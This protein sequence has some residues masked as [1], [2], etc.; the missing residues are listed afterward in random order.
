MPKHLRKLLSLCF[1]TMIG[2]FTSLT[3]IGQPVN[4]NCTEAILLTP[5]TSCVFTQYTNAGATA[6]T[7]VDNPIC[8]NY[9]GMDVWFKFVVPSTGS[10]EIDAQTGTM[11]DG[12][13][14]LYSGVCGALNQLT[15]DDDNSANGLMP[16]I[17][18]SGLV[19]GSTAYI[20]FWNYGT[21]MPGTFS[22]CVK[23]STSSGACSNNNPGGCAC[24]TPGATDC[25]L[26][27][28]IIAGK[29]SLNDNT[30][31]SEYSQLINGVNKGLLR[32]DVSTPNVG[33]GPMEVTPTN[34]Y[35]CGGDTMRNFFPATNFLCP[36]GSYPKRLINQRIYHKIGNT[37]EYLLRPAGYMQYHPA[38]GHIH[39]DGWGLYTLRLKDASIADTIKWPIVN[40]G[41]KVSFCLIDLTTCSGS[42]GDCRDANGTILNNGSFPNYGLGGGY[43]CGNQL[44]GISV[45]KVDI[46]HRNLDESFVK[47]PYEACNGEYYAMIE[48]DPDNHFLEM[49]ENNN[50]LAAKVPL[51]QQRTTNTGP[52]AYIFSKKGNVMCQGDVMELV[53]SGASNYV[54]STGETTQK[55]NVS[56]PGRYWV[57]AT[58][59]CGVATSDTLDLF[60]SGASSIPATVIEDTVCVG[61]RANLFASGNA[62][63][64]DAATGGNLIH[65]GNNFQTGT[66]N[67]SITFYVA[68]QPTV[69][70]DSLGA[71][72]TNLTTTGVNNLSWNEYLIFNAF[73][74][75]K[76][77]T[78]TVTSATAGLM[79][80]E[81]RDMYGNPITKKSV[82]LVAGQQDVLLDFHVPSG[83]NHQL[84]FSA[85]SPAPAVFSNTTTSN[86]IGYP[87]S[88]SSVARIVGSSLGDK[89]YPFFYNWQIEG[90]SQ[91]CNSGVRK[92]VTATVAPDVTASITGL[93]PL[94]LHTSPQANLQLNPPGGV[95]SGPGVTGSVFNPAAA[96]VG[97]HQ[98]TYNYAF[99]SCTTSAS[100][101]T[102]V[103]FDSSTI[104]YGLNVQ[105]YNNIGS[106][107]RLYVVTDQN[108]PVELRLYN[109]VGQL[110]STAKYA[111]TRGSN[112]FNVEV[113]RLAKGMYILDVRHAATGTRKIFKMVN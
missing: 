70:E 7:G 44:Q 5:G 17:A 103:L 57:R 111:A 82:Q 2:I 68:D 86:N 106:N 90:A 18:F 84:G 30:G 55:I 9:N 109:S 29:R 61:G 34:D 10:V 51:T 50:W 67:N 81:L 91:A 79:I 99:G 58:T 54:W 96:G 97:I 107:P 39:L 112:M 40:S 78:V 3:V 35:I 28:D 52:Y 46:Y 102:E 36:D 4:D 65:I 27:P 72:N 100:V 101:T 83:L 20:R 21:T 62:H 98:L 48:I 104:E 32:L 6:S 12:C 49:D 73:I 95:L 56:Q 25:Y 89:H 113:S 88:L 59:P 23:I 8:S 60:S 15:C 33:W 24:P 110:V 71:A 31:Y 92:P 22:I 47:I 13:M 93:D 53:A 69:L 45:G 94:Y 105:L 76:L 64:F 87:F 80:I 66:L 38:H 77:K 1:I 41:I 74:P 19:P 85:S 42:L 43:N 75:F 108:S 26:I 11:T 14:S 63:W 37:F 16:F